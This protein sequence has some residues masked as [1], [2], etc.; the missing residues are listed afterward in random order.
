MQKHVL[1]FVSLTHL[2]IRSVKAQLSGKNTLASE[3]FGS[4]VTSGTTTGS[5][6]GCTP[7]SPSGL[8]MKSI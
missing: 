5:A 8:L 7:S 2:A 6:D 1:A 3:V 4:T